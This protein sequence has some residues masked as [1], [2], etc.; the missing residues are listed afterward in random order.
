MGKYAAAFAASYFV[1]VLVKDGTAGS[2]FQDL[3]NGGKDLA[4]GLKPITTVG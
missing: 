4:K 3:A 2:L 1:L